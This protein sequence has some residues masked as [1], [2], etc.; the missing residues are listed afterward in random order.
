MEL[1]VVGQVFFPVAP[2][3]LLAVGGVGALQQVFDSEEVA[4]AATS[5]EVGASVAAEAAGARMWIQ[6][7][8]PGLPPGIR[9]ER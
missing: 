5:A 2:V 7:R 8:Q 9:L 6:W 4:A 3:G 1:L